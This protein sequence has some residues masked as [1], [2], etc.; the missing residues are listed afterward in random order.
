MTLSNFDK[1]LPTFQ[2]NVGNLKTTVM[3]DTGAEPRAVVSATANF[4]QNL[5]LR[6]CD[7]LIKSADGNQFIVKGQ[8]DFDLR[9]SENFTI[10]LTNVPV[11]ENMKFDVILGYPLL[12]QYGFALIPKNKS[13]FMLNNQ[14][15]RMENSESNFSNQ[16]KKLKANS[17]IEICP[18]STKI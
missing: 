4:L 14:K 8:I 7:K 10:S 5:K 18:V 1:K 11:I 3:A 6:N 16:F 17:K 9:I 2:A 13:F 12:L 15:I